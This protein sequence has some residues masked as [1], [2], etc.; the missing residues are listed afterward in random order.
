MVR[1]KQALPYM[2]DILLN[3]LHCSGDGRRLA[4]FSEVKGNE[5]ISKICSW[6]WLLLLKT[7]YLLGSS[8]S[9]QYLCGVVAI[10][11]HCVAQIEWLSWLRLI[12]VPASYWMRVLHVLSTN[13]KQCL[14]SDNWAVS[15][16][17]G[18]PDLIHRT[19]VW[20]AWN[21]E[22]RAPVCFE[23]FL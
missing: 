1:A 16:W 10:Q 21:V 9:R 13:E 6:G 3:F 20:K 4:S 2:A 19:K 11:G 14:A 18:L 12:T 17:T 22:S 23:Y 5:T 8:N 15:I 7:D